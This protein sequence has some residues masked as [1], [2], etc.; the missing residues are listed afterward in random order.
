MNPERIRVP[1][2]ERMQFFGNLSTMLKAGIP[3]LE[4][5]SSLQEE[6]KGGVKKV[7]ETI[8]EDL[9]AGR[10]LHESLKKYPESFDKVT[11]SLIKAS[12]EAGTLERTL[13]DVRDNLQREME[14]SDKVKSALMYPAFVLVVFFG[15]MIAM[16]VFVMPRISQVFSRLKMD[17]PLPTR[18]L[19]AASDALM[20]H[21]ILIGAIFAV[22]IIITIVFYHFKRRL[23]LNT[24]FSLPFLSGIIREIDLTKYTRSLHLL[25]SSGVP[26]ITALQLAED[27]VIKQDLYK[28]LVGARERVMSGEK[29]ASGLK[30]D[31]KII[32]GVVIK[33]VEVGERTGSLDESMKD[34]TEMLD[35]RVSKRLEKAT[36]LLEPIML[37]FV[38]LAVGAMMLSIIGPIYGLISDVSPN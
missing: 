7:L 20:N 9:Q 18:I 10:V 14:F 38:G 12:E 3:I 11:V 5:V 37:V 36:A 35:Y 33:L 21:Y 26:I 22:L 13:R 30:S 6:T 2:K 32:S 16:M 15:V 19:M 28:V 25:L 23:V 1:G 4:A 29:L 17:L 31:N 8:K 34:V 27:V 24:V